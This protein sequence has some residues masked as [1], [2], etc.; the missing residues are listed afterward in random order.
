MSEPLIRR[1]N[2]E[3][4]L[5]RV[6]DVGTT[7]R[8]RASS[9]GDLGTGRAPGSGR[10]LRGYRVQR[11]G[12]RTARLR[13]PAADQLV[14][15]RL[16]P[17]HR[18]GAGG[19]AARRVGAGVAVADGMRNRELPVLPARPGE[20]ANGNA[21]GLPHLQPAT[22]DSPA[23]T[24]FRTRCRLNPQ[25]RDRNRETPCPN[26]TTL[27]LSAA[28]SSALAL[29]HGLSEMVFSRLRFSR[30]GCRTADAL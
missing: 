29:L 26:Q 25:P 6:V 11:G 10:L 17:R 9:A 15:L 1:I 13:S 8:G 18:V 2:R 14:D 22:V 28:L 19:G 3:Q 5:W 16:Q 23:Q 4:M 30:S 7:D 27:P 21:L 12:R 20:S 24:L